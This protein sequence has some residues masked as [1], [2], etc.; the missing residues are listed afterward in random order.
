MPQFLL[1]HGVAGQEGKNVRM[2][3]HQSVHLLKE[4]VLRSNTRG[5]SSD[6]FGR[7]M[8]K[9]DLRTSQRKG[10]AGQEEDRPNKAGEGKG[11]TQKRQVENLQENQQVL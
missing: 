2:N 4:V 5:L 9:G 1:Q 10:A 6:C 8:C 7:R 3:E 11:G